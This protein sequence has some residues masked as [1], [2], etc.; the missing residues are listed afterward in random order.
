VVAVGTERARHR[1]CFVTATCR[2]SAEEGVQTSKL[3]LMKTN[4]IL[5]LLTLVTAAVLASCS[6]GGSAN[7]RG[8]G[9][10]SASVSGSGSISDDRR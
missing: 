7:V 3:I 6:A 2:R 9:I 10:G 4:L 5:A 1:P 8:S